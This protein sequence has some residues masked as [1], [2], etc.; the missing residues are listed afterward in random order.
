[1]H[2]LTG[3]DFGQAAQA[4]EAGEY[5]TLAAVDVIRRKARRPAEAGD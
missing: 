3:M 1:V 4:I 5:A 2:H